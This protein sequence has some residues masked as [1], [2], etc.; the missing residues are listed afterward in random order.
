MLHSDTEDSIEVIT[1][2]N[3]D[4]S[5]H[6]GYVHRCAAVNDPGSAL[7]DAGTARDHCDSR[8]SEALGDLETVDPFEELTSLSK[9]RG[10]EALAYFHVGHDED[11]LARFQG[12]RARAG[13]EGGKVVKMSGAWRSVEICCI[14]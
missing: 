1:L 9:G 3:V 12:E 10:L 14:F 5:T 4:G 7:D 2:R 13:R 6:S 11:D 8:V